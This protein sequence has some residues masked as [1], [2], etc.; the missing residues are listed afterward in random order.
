MLFG[1]P[2]HICG[3]LIAFLLLQLRK[4][5]VSPVLY[6]SVQ[7]PGFLFVGLPLSDGI[8]EANSELE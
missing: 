2:F 4:F 7:K 3:N 1:V 8:L 6:D 5:K